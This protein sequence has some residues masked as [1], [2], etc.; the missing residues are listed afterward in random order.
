ML[1]ENGRCPYCGMKTKRTSQQNKMYWALLTLINEQLKVKGQ[2]YTAETWSE[3]L[4]RRYLGAHELVLPNG[5]T[6]T[7]TVSTSSLDKEEFAEY[8]D[9]CIAWAAEHSIV[10]PDREGNI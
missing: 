10:L 3:Y 5:K 1:K 2:G 6:I 8:V 4:K 9:K 7:I